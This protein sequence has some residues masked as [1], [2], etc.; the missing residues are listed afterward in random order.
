MPLAAHHSLSILR[1]ILRAS[2]M[3][4]RSHTNAVALLGRLR[5]GEFTVAR[6]ANVDHVEREP[7]HYAEQVADLARQRQ[8]VVAVIDAVIDIEAEPQAFGCRLDH[9]AALLYQQDEEF[10]AC[11]L[12][13]RFSPSLRTHH[14]GR[15]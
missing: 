8:L 2:V 13:H 9:L 15:R 5:P 11:K 14:R 3:A 4:H 12:S 7:I 1:A 10:V 6:N